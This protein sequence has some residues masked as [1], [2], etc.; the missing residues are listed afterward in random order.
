LTGRW[1]PKWT[2]RSSAEAAEPPVAALPLR[3]DGQSR[4]FRCCGRVFAAHLSTVDS[5]ELTALK[6][7]KKT[8]ALYERAGELNRQLERYAYATTVRFSAAE[9]D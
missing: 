9:V 7:G 5:Y 6:L 2:T 8:E 1:L 4:R 3:S